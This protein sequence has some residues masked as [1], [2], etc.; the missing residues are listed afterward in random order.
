MKLIDFHTHV[1]PG[2][3]DGARDV[4]ESVSILEALAKQGVGVVYATPHFYAD[5]ESVSEFA[6]R[7]EKAYAALT[8]A[9]A[10]RDDLPEV[11]LGAEIMICKELSGFNLSALRFEDVPVMLF[12]YPVSRYHSWFASIAEKLAATYSCTAMV[13]HFDRYPWLDKKTLAAFTKYGDEMLFQMNCTGLT[14]RLA[15]K[16]L[17]AL[18][19]SNRTVVFG[20]DSHDLDA[21]APSFDVLTKAIS[22][23]GIKV[24][25]GKIKPAVLEEL[26][27]RSQNEVYG[28]S[29]KNS[30]GLIG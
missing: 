21:H 24:G 30:I 12:E 14:D 16:T 29:G 13:A 10:D 25:L 15:A 1:L 17:A 22:G 7:R 3:D 18:I 4:S 6:D 23:K 26:I 19:K 28:L 2:M 5:M 27:D 9:I 11:R 8:E 20:S